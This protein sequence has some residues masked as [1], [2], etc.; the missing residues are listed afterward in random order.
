[1][2]LT[3]LT[4]IL[5]P[6]ILMSQSQGNPPKPMSAD[7][8]ITQMKQELSLT[9]TQVTQITPV[10]KSDVSQIESLMKQERD[11]SITRDTAREKMDAIRKS[12]ETELAK[13]LT[14]EQLAKWKSSHKPPKGDRPEPR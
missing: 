5:L 8:M 9:D 12:T 14:S 11:G 6:T 1:M 10:I 4:L 13:Y 2:Y 7:E 3:A